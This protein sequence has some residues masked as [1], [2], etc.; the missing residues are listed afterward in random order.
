M[1]GAV[2]RCCATVVST[3]VDISAP[4]SSEY[5]E[6]EES[7]FLDTSA[8]LSFSDVTHARQQTAVIPAAGCTGG[9]RD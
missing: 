1:A 2:V 9:K 5:D 3:S 7:P 6:D 8:D 4:L